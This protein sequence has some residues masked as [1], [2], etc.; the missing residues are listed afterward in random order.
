MECGQANRGE[1]GY[2]HDLT[3]IDLLLTMAFPRQAV[4]TRGN[5]FA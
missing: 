3:S 5:G 2:H 1:L 4:A